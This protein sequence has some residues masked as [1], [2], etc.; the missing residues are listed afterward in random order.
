MKINLRSLM[1]LIG[2]PIVLFTMGPMAYGQAVLLPP[3][4]SVTIR[5][6]TWAGS[7]CP[8][9]T[10]SK[11]LDRDAQAFTLA[12][13]SFIAVAG[14]TITDPRENRKNCNII[15]D[16]TFPSGWSFTIFTVDYRGFAELDRWVTATQR[17]A[18]FFEGQFPS[19][20][21]STRLVGP[22][23][24]I[25][26]ER[27]DS[28]GL[29]NRIWSPCGGGRALNINAEV[30]VSNMANRQGSGQMTLDTVTGT[31]QHIYGLQWR[32]CTSE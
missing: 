10:V 28:L 7:G 9:D 30:R 21:L 5:N 27:R 32:R 2:A 18:Y 14:P 16:F 13:D 25:N 1:V 11:N 23:A 8:A 31:V 15:I 17:S 24:G 26:Y 22:I 3:V 4:G 19:A 20:A 29:L 6:L 12:F